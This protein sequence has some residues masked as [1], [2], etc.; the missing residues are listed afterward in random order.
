MPTPAD[1]LTK[2]S[3]IVGHEVSDSQAKLH[4]SWN[5]HEEGCAVLQRIRTMQ[6]QLR[7]LKQEVTR[8]IA[9][10]KSDYTTER[11]RVGKTLASGLA[12]GVSIAASGVGTLIQGRISRWW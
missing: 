7:F 10:V 12:A 2:L 11:M 1:F 6:K 3:D 4:L 5:N 9:A 8:A